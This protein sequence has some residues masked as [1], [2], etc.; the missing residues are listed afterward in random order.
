MLPKTFKGVFAHF[1]AGRSVAG[2][3]PSPGAE[4]P[5]P[6]SPTGPG[7]FLRD[8]GSLRTRRCNYSSCSLQGSI[9]KFYCRLHSGS[10]GLIMVN[11]PHC[12][13]IWREFREKRAMTEGKKW[14]RSTVL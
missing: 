5:E 10:W 3:T 8:V 1:W 9:K 2:N 12:G 4:V 14:R 11:S 7:S 6:C 13:P